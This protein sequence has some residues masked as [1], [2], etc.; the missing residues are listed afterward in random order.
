MT[1]RAKQ[2]F[3]RVRWWACRMSWMFSTIWCSDEWNGSEHH[4][5]PAGNLVVYQ[6]GTCIHIDRYRH[7]HEVNAPVRRV[8]TGD[9][10]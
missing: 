7:L 4:L 9:G 3:A 10:R 8:R 5:T 6:T 2:N 1:D